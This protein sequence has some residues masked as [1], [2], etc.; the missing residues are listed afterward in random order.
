[1]L[2]TICPVSA[3]V[4]PLREEN[5]RGRDIPRPYLMLPPLEGAYRYEPGQKLLFGLTLFGNIVQFL[6]YLMLSIQ[7]LEVVGI[8]RRMHAG[9]RGRFRVRQVEAYNPLSGERQ[10]LYEKG[11]PLVQ[12]PALAVTAA[13]VQSRADS[14]NAEQLTLTFL[15]PTR[16][17]DQEHLVHKPHFRPLMQRLIE[18]LSA[19][20]SAYGEGQ[21]LEKEAVYQLCEQAQGI[22]CCEDTTRWEDLPSYSHRLKRSTPVGGLLGS[23]TFTGDLT[24]FRELLVWGELVHVG[25]SC[26]KGNGWYHIDA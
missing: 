10:C 13:D 16:I 9:E 6:P 3:L 14:L 25:K 19:L 20:E 24:P 26:V 11:R 2:H 4:A 21:N 18:R 8:G 23:A 12:V 1:M 15:T 22:K 7:A 17:V 5:A